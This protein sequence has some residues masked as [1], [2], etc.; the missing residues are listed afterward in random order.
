MGG[1]R[2]S[3]DGTKAAVTLGGGNDFVYAIIDLVNRGKPTVIATAETYKEAG[4]RAVQ[5]YRWANDR[6]PAVDPRFTRKHP[7]TA[8]GFVAAGNLRP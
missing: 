4:Q 3:P 5:G 2:L 1:I 7:G 6:Y 8:R